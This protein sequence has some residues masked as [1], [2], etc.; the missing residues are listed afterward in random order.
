LAKRN[1]LPY[2]Y[3]KSVDRST[4]WRCENEA[5]DKYLGAELSDIDLLEKFLERKDSVK[6]IGS[7]LRLTASISNILNASGQFQKILSGNKEEFV[8]SVIRFPKYQY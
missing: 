6:V 7:Y 2:K 8:R 5:D 3:S 4:L 1:R